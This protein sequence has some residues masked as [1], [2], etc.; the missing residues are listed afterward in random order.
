MRRLGLALGLSAGLLAAACGSKSSGPAGP[1]NTTTDLTGTWNET[2]GGDLTWVLT[3]TGSNVTGSTSFS[4]DSGPN[5]GAVSGKGIMSGTV[6]SGLFNFTDTYATLSKA[7][8]SMT[9]SGQMTINGTTMSGRY[10]EVDSC[11]G[12]VLGTVMGNI[13]MRKQ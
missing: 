11:N 2:P 3:Q 13:A 12:A 7:N 6:S 5:L 4:Q 9:V 8:C 10:T 1:T